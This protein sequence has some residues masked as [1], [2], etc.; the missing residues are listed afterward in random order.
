MI[1]YLA[2]PRSGFVT[3]AEFKIDGGV[4]ARISIAPRP[5]RQARRWPAT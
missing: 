1:A 3:G 2:G 4:L 5:G